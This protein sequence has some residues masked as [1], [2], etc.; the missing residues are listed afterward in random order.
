MIKNKRS[1]TCKHQAN[2][3]LNICCLFPCCHRLS[4]HSPAY[5]VMRCSHLHKT[6]FWICTS[7]SSQQRLRTFALYKLYKQS[8][9]IG[10]FSILPSFS[11]YFLCPQLPAAKHFLYQNQKALFLSHNCDCDGHQPQTLCEPY[12]LVERKHTSCRQRLMLVCTKYTNPAL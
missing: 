12:N 3:S 9:I 10:C 5:S 11:L 2:Y 7:Y 1:L 8:I 6:S 4:K